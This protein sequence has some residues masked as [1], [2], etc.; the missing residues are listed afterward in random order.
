MDPER[1]AVYLRTLS[2]EPD[3]LLARMREEAEREGIPIVRPETAAFLRT[4]AAIRQPKQ[5]LEV[6]TAIGYSALL[7]LSVL[8]ADGRL[9]S[10]ERSEALRQRAEQFRAQAGEENRLTLL[11][12]DAAEIL[13]RLDVPCDLIFLD[14]A[15]GQYPVMLPELMRL[16][17][18]GG[19]LVT[20]NVLQDG[21]VLESRFAVPRRDRTIHR[22]MRDYLYELTHRA[23]LMTSVLPV[24]DGV[25]LSV[26]T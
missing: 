20:D 12:G 13:P 11:A 19:V 10:I 21:T 6:G 24:G 3:A 7:M 26:R 23:D 22:R 5:V 25:A 15:K 16:L 4:I 2:S 1:L 18:P 8:P 14:A 17:A 9:T